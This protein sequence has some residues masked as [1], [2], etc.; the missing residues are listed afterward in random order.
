MQLQILPGNRVLT[1]QNPESPATG[2]G[3]YMLVADLAVEDFLVE[4]LNARLADV[5]GACVVDRIDPLQLI[6]IDTPDKS[7]GMGRQ[8]TVGVIPYQLSLDLDAR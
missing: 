1:F 6:P 8:L 5:V 4:P 2:I 7:Q 3:F